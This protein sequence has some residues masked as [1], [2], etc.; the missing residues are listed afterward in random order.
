MTFDRR[1]F[2][3]SAA[4]LGGAA[5]ASPAR[6]ASPYVEAAAY[7]GERRGVSMLVMQGDQIVFEDYPNEGGR[8]RAWELASGTKS[9]SGVLAAAMVQDGLLRLDER[10]AE[11]LSEW[12]SEPGEADVTVRQLL[13]LTGGVGAGQIGRPPT[14]ANAVAAPLAGP[15]GR[16][17]RYGPAPF[18]VFGEIVRRKL[19]AAG[20]SDDVYAYLEARLLRPLDIRPGVWR[21]QD[22]QPNLPSGAHLTAR[23]WVKLGRFV[24]DGGRLNGRP[25]VDPG[26]LAANFEPTRINPGYGLT[27][28]LLRPGMIGPGRRAGIEESGAAAA[29]YADVRMA[30]GAGDQRLYLLPDRDLLIVRQASGVG[31]SLRGQGTGWSDDAFLRL[32]LGV[33]GAAVQ[34]SPARRER[35]R[36]FRRDP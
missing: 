27:W 23:D 2:L 17:F 5:L 26:A 7:S 15:P 19:A 10:C 6:A 4:A 21:R 1:A 14:Y 18:Q 16:A 20:R 31:R 22:G 11:T 25:L 33:G 36:R 32:A 34:A 8:E 13:T 3:L 29:R 12:R 24:L 30:A 9:F 35:P 28:W